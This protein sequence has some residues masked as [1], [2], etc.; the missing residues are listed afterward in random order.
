MRKTLALIVLALFMVLSVIGCGGGNSSNGGGNG[1]TVSGTV[2]EQNTGI[3]LAG[4]T[5][6]LG[7]KTATTNA[8]GKYSFSG[9]PTGSQT[10]QAQLTGYTSFSKSVDIQN[11]QTIDID[12]VTNGPLVLNNSISIADKDGNS[13]ADGASLP[14]NVTAI[15]LSGNIYDL[16]A[17]RNTGN[18]FSAQSTGIT[19]TQLQA[20]I[21]GSVY[22]I[23]IE[24]DGSY[25]QMVPLAPG[26]NSIQLRVFD[27]NGDAGTG[28]VM[29]IQVTLAKLDI[30]VVLKWDTDETDVDLHLFKRLASEANPSVISTS[31]DPWW[32]DEEDINQHICFY[33]KT[34]I[35]FGTGIQNPFL[36]IDDMDGYGP[37]TLV[38]QEATTGR[39][40]IWVHYYSAYNGTDEIPSNVQVNIVL[41]GG[42]DQAKV[43]TYDKR[44]T[45]DWEFW[46][47]CTIDWPSATIVNQPPAEIYQPTGIFNSTSLYKKTKKK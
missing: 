37:E 38:L 12:L 40:H 5:V 2:K 28:Q 25:D 30:R 13:Y 44:L 19:I 36:D 23:T 11:S 21:N 26:S 41:K 22:Q 34:P 8:E 42:T 18:I 14:E 7:T 33:N 35:D 43:F 31:F 3:I 45:K 32:S 4:V 39:Y 16:V 15:R 1:I 46:Y 47:V 20:L 17:P 29:R 27:S 10:I 6:S 9:V 24:P